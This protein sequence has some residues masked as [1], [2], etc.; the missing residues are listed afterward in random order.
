ML[1]SPSGALPLGPP[2]AA[3]L[4]RHHIALEILQR[5]AVFGHQL[6]AA[7][8]PRLIAGLAAAAAGILIVRR[9]ARL[10]LLAIRAARRAAR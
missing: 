3:A 1:P 6:H 8:I 5:E 7:L 2:P 10:L 9:A 4:L